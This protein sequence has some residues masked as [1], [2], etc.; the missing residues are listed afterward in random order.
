MLS[1]KERGKTCY[2]TNQYDTK[3]MMTKARS[4]FMLKIYYFEARNEKYYIH[5][6]V[7]P[8]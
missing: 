5:A 6:Y 7:G 8:F 3:F 1:R 4:I 2:S